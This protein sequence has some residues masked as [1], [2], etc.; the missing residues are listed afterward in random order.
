MN[1]HSSKEAGLFVVAGCTGPRNERWHGRVGD[2]V[3]EVLWRIQNQ[4]AV[5][6]LT[7]RKEGQS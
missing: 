6:I 4:V 5:Q 7:Q 2:V 3:R 1:G